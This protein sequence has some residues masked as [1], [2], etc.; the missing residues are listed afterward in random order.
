MQSNVLMDATEKNA[1]FEDIE[2]ILETEEFVPLSE[3]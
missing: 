3:I 2:R 1:F